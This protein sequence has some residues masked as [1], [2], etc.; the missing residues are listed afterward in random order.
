MIGRLSVGWNP[1]GKPLMLVP[2]LSHTLTCDDVVII[3]YVSGER[4]EPDTTLTLESAGSA[5]PTESSHK[6]AIKRKEH[7]PW[8]Q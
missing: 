1:P 4:P 6:C 3:H 8:N 5:T 2:P 7:A